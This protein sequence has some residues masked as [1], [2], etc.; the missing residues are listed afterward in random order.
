MG[1]GVTSNFNQS[2]SWVMRMRVGYL[3][4]DN[5]NYGFHVLA[6]QAW[7]LATG[8]TSG[9]NPRKENIPLTIDHSY[10]V[11]FDFTRNWQLRLVQ[12]FGPMFAVGV[13]IENPAEIVF[14][15]TGGVG[16]GGTVNGL[17][18]NF[19]NAGT[20]NLGTGALF[21]TFTPDHAPDIIGKAAFDPGWAHF[22]VFGIQRFFTDNVFACNVV[23]PAGACGGN[24]TGAA[25]L[26][27]STGEGIG[28][29]VLWPIL[30][31]LLD[32]T[33]STLYG[34]GVGRYG[35]SQLPDV[36]V[37]PDGS[38]R[39]IKAWH[40][41]AGVVLHPWVG[42]DIY[43]YGGFEKEDPMFFTAMGGAQLGLGNPALSNGGCAAPVVGNFNGAG[44][45]QCAAANNNRIV[46]DFTVGI[47]QNLYNGDVG[48]V[49]TGLQYEYIRRKSFDFF[50]GLANI[51]SLSTSDNVFYTSLR[52][53]PKYPTF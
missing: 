11:G 2:N 48:R 36:A 25:G 7:S 1:S 10:V 4:Y 43:A 19:A 3:T 39:P 28:G 47:W 5:A 27:N 29:S 22:E 23:T 38:L 35:A 14:T 34:K 17:V 49:A 13:S 40:G 53:Y 6:G 12:D 30:P 44:G 24:S 50:D 33:A 15:G 41:L 20:T 21:N 45:L 26:K 9:I 31:G 37:G 18:V 42:T 32:V 51:G 46:T 8:N 16:S 52:W